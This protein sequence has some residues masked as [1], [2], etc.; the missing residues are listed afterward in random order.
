MQTRIAENAGMMQKPQ[1]GH[2]LQ[3]QNWSGMFANWLGLF[4]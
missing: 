1:Q 4:F 2:T 3:L